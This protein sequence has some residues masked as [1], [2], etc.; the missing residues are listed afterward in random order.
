MF[1]TI[2][3]IALFVGIFVWWFFLRPKQVVIEEPMEM[4]IETPEVIEKPP[5]PVKEPP[6]K[7]KK[8]EKPNFMISS[9]WDGERDGYVFKS[10]DKGLGY[11]LDRPRVSFGTNEVVPYSPNESPEQTGLRYKKLV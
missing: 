5:E 3:I 2:L 1:F 8:P 10:G 6:K 9:Q 4:E 11:Y 7:K